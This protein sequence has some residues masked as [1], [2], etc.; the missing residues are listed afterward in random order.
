MNAQSFIFYVG[1][2]IGTL[3]SNIDDPK[4]IEFFESRGYKRGN[5]DNLKAEL[6]K[7]ARCLYGESSSEVRNESGAV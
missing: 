1:I 6:K 2:L 5:F 4:F 7:I 3:E